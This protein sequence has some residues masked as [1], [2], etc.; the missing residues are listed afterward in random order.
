[1]LLRATDVFFRSGTLRGVPP[2]ELITWEHLIAALF[3]TPWF[4]GIQPL[5]NLSFRDWITLLFVAW[6]VSVGGIL[7]FTTAFSLINPAIVI[8]LQ[9]LQPIITIILSILILRERV[10]PSFYPLAG[11]AI[12]SAWVLVFGFSIPDITLQAGQST[13]A[14]LALCA[15]AL[16]G[17]GTT[18]GK[19][20]LLK[21]DSRTLTH[22]RYYFGLMFALY[23]SARAGILTQPAIFD[24]PPLLLNVMYM[25]LVPGMAAL[26]FFYAGLQHTPA[27]MASILELFFPVASVIIAWVF[28]GQRLTP[29]QLGAAAV[30]LVTIIAVSRLSKT[31]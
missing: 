15:A 24:N 6:G 1:M 4:P 16:W 23:L 20:L 29:T 13:G 2:L 19:S 9:K 31:A 12:A 25:A 5:K 10:V 22:Y 17:S 7:C 11:V 14:I 27:A 30:L 8:L 21:M 28:L 26:F 3:L 18:F